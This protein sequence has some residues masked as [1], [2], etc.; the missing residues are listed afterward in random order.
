MPDDPIDFLYV[1]INSL[2]LLK[3]K[4]GIID[5]PNSKSSC[6]EECFSHKNLSINILKLYKCECK[7]RDNKMISKNNYFIDIPLNLPFWNNLLSKC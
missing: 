2:H 7:G 5:N 6:S 1:I 4:K 3:L